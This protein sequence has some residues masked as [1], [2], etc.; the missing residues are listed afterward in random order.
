MSM[1]CFR[2]ISIS[3]GIPPYNCNLRCQAP[4]SFF[5]G[6]PWVYHPRDK[7]LSLRKGSMKNLKER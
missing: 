2:F 4:P 5:N 3:N 1:F 6:G 7:Q